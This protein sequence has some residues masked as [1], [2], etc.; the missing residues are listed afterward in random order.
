MKRRNFLRSAYLILGFA[1]A[2]FSKSNAAASPD[3]GVPK[4]LGDAIPS[5]YRKLFGQGQTGNSDDSLIGLYRSS[6]IHWH[7]L[8]MLHADGSYRLLFWK[9]SEAKKFSYDEPR[10][11]KGR[12]SR[13][14]TDQGDE[15]VTLDFDD[16]ELQSGSDAGD[17][18]LLLMR[19]TD[20]RYLLRPSELNHMA[21]NIRENNRLGRSDGY[22]FSA[23][24][25]DLFFEEP[26]EGRLSPPIADLPVKLRRLV[27]A[28]P[29]SMTIVAV[30][31]PVIFDE[32][33]GQGDIMCTLSLG[34]KDGL[35]MN[36]PLFSPF[37]SGKNL[38]GWVWGMDPQN[39]RAGI[40]YFRSSNAV[41]D[42]PTVGDILVSNAPRDKA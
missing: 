7:R 18:Q 14:I 15:L 23:T 27:E 33:I 26:F 25:S 13:E 5:E 24:L 10:M 17:Q 4:T 28:K 34:Q 12:Y 16:Q 2:L 19:S 8:L 3:S 20:Q 6:Y 38:R 9:S 32:E 36:M 35:Y 21:F 42:L 29:L 11:Y 39:C 1:H 41:T 30:A 37:G 40:R 31:E 22:L